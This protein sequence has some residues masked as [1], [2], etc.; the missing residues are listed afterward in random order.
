MCVCVCACVCS[1]AFVC[2]LSTYYKYKNIHS[3]GKVRTFWELELRLGVKAGVRTGVR[4]GFVGMGRV[5][6]SPHV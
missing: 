1:H 3:T 2:V 6:E 4:L 5:V